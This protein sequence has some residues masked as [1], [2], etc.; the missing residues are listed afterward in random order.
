MDD[1]ISH[2]GPSQP[3]ASP[4]VRLLS[5]QCIPHDDFLCCRVPHVLWHPGIGD[6]QWVAHI[7]CITLIFLA[8]TFGGFLLTVYKCIS[9]L[10][11]GRRTHMPVTRLFLRDGIIWFLAVF[12]SCF[13]HSRQRIPD[14]DS[15]HS[16]D[17]RICG[18]VG[19]SSSIA[20]TAHSY[21]CSAP[22][23]LLI[24]ANTQLLPMP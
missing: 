22:S 18:H 9:T 7:T 1:S 2:A 6:G 8:Q 5:H 3:D 12:C 11:W 21:V 13:N 24:I 16:H 14:N 23:L 10:K 17:D 20:L 19:F 15:T 4:L